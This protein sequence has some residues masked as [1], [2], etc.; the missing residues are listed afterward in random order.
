MRRVQAPSRDGLD[1]PINHLESGRR[2]CPVAVAVGVAHDEALR[3]EPVRNR[4]CRPY[5]GGARWSSNPLFKPR[6]RR[7]SHAGDGSWRQIG[8]RSSV[9]PEATKGAICWP[10]VKPSDG[11]EPSTPSLPSSNEAGTRAHPGS[12]GH[13]SRARRRKRPKT[14][15]RGWTWVPALVLPQRSLAGRARSCVRGEAAVAASPRGRA[16]TPCAGGR[17]AR[18]RSQRRVRLRRGGRLRATRA[19]RC[20]RRTSDRR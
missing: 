6:R 11:L 4:R 9:A 3:A 12:R 15:A 7:N 8:G 20:G 16:T 1:F 5:H 10:F 17:R 19:A 14:S 18:R 2:R 13:E